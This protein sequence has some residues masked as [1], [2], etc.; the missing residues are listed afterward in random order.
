MLQK[1]RL[2]WISLTLLSS[3]LT[4]HSEELRT[5]HLQLLSWDSAVKARIP[6]PDADP[7]DVLATR[8]KISYVYKVKVGNSLQLHQRTQDPKTLGGLM[9]T[10]AIPANVSDLLLLVSP[11]GGS[12][13][14][15]ALPFT[16]SN[17]PINS[18]TIFNLT[19][20]PVTGLIE[21]QPQNI[22]PKGRHQLIY[23]YVYAQKESVRTKFAIE[24]DGRLRLVQN[25]FIP[26]QDKGRVL[27]FI[28]RKALEEGASSR[29]SVKF[30][31]A[32]DVM[33]DPDRAPPPEIDEAAEAEMWRQLSL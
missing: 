15:A 22:E 9:A 29:R 14:A 11:K 25:G 8:K 26:I 1:Y 3:L 30:T 6:Q 2:Y 7:I 19:D 23:Q 17:F 21:G 28:T 4:A 31:Y 32:Y 12:I 10:V 5:V 27:F 16:R 13:S 18:L 33:P 24:H 20:R